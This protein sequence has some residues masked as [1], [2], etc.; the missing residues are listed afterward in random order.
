MKISNFILALIGIY[1][2]NGEDQRFEQFL[3]ALTTIMGVEYPSNWSN[4]EEKLS[5]SLNEHTVNHVA[6]TMIIYKEY[7]KRFKNH[8]ESK[9]LEDLF[10][11]LHKPL[12]WILKELETENCEE[13]FKM[14][15]N[16]SKILIS[17]ISEDNIFILAEIYK[18]VLDSNI[19][20]LTN[21]LDDLH[22]TSQSKFNSDSTNKDSTNEDCI[23]ETS[24]K[25]KVE[26]SQTLLNLEK[27]LKNLAL[28]YFNMILLKYGNTDSLEY[29]EYHI[30]NQFVE[31]YQKP[32][33]EYW[34]EVI[35]QGKFNYTHL[36]FKLS[37]NYHNIL[38]ISLI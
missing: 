10:E 23:R 31:I 19:D 4:L 21:T 24:I 27:K 16:A 15:I 29:H 13:S 28:K 30:S 14:R 35:R 5:L 37:F 6:I 9:V 34:Y 3:L 38:F 22:L 20:H 12:T 18:S 2:T 1:E 25:T 11:K 17:K 32:I 7:F 33:A 8:L 26:Q 36:S